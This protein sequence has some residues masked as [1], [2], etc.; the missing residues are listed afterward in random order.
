MSREATSWVWEHSQARGNDRLVHLMLANEADSDGLDARCSQRRMAELGRCGQATVRRGVDWLEAAGEILVKR[1]EKIGRGRY[2]V[3]ALVMGRDPTELAAQIG[4]P[5]PRTVP[6]VVQEWEQ[7]RLEA[8][9]R[10][11]RHKANGYDRKSMTRSVA[12]YPIVE[13]DEYA[14]E[15]APVGSDTAPDGANGGADPQTHLSD[16]RGA[17]SRTAVG[18]AKNPTQSAAEVIAA[19]EE[20]ARL[21]ELEQGR[22]RVKELIGRAKGAIPDPPEPKPVPEPPPPKPD[23]DLCPACDHS[24]HGG[25]T[26]RVEDDD[27]SCLCRWPEALAPVE[28]ENGWAERR[29]LQ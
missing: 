3:Y 19:D 5:P 22:G 9:S 24:W 20:A 1:P 15:C 16:P 23:P 8:T 29:D 18:S 17:A 21:V 27:R 4:W 12:P 14:P 6:E 26:C 13:P 28:V 7:L 2:T 10:Q 25:E 11:E